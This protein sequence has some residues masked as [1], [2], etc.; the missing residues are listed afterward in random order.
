MLCRYEG[1]SKFA[2]F[3]RVKAIPLNFIVVDDELFLQDLD[4][5][6]AIGLLLLRQHDLPEITLT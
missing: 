5:I 1:V 4:R 2:A 3:E 6:Q